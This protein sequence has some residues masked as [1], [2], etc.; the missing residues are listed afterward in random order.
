MDK[1]E[2]IALVE[3]A[4]ATDLDMDACTEAAE[5]LVAVGLVEDHD[6]QFDV[7]LVQLSEWPDSVRRFVSGMMF[8]NSDEGR[9]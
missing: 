8:W 9:H 4:Q 7:D 1:A 3:K 2:A 5:A 6:D